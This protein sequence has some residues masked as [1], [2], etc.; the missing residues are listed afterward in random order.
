MRGDPDIQL[1]EPAFQ[2]FFIG[3]EKE[4]VLRRVRH[5]DEEAR[6]AV[7]VDDSFLLPGASNGLRLPR[8]CAKARAQIHEG[9]DQQAFRHGRAI[10]KE[11]RQQDLVAA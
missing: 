2:L 3:R 9:F 8:S 10:V 4:P 7:P 11:Q 1:L 5:I 6:Q